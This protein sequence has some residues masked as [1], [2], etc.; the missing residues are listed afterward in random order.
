MSPPCA[1]PLLLLLLV[2]LVGGL[3]HPAGVRCV[4]G[5]SRRRLERVNAGCREG[6]EVR[7]LLEAATLIG[8]NEL[9]DPFVRVANHFLTEL[10]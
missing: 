6:F 7:Q 3:R 2:L 4:V 5:T 10:L 1:D 8:L 9:I